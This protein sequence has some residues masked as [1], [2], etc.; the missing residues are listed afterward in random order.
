MAGFGVAYRDK[1]IQKSQEHDYTIVIHEQSPADKTKRPLTEIISPGTFFPEDSSDSEHNLSN[2]VMCIWLH[3]SNATKSMPSQVSIGLA[4][5]DIFTGK[6]ALFQFAATYIHS[7]STYDELER[8]ISAY[9]PSECIF[10]ANIPERLIDDIIGFVGLEKT[11]MHKVGGNPPEP[12][13]DKKSSKGGLEACEAGGVTPLDKKMSKG[14]CGGDPPSGL[15]LFAKNAEKQNYQLQTLKR[16]F[17]HLSSVEEMFP[18]HYIATQAFCFL[19][20]FV[21]QH[22]PNLSKKLTEPVFENYTDRLILANQTLNQLNI[23]DDSRYSGKMRSLSSFLNNCVTLMG[24]R[25]FLYQ[26]HYPTTHEPTLQASYDITEHLLLA[27]QTLAQQ[28]YFSYAMGNYG[29]DLISWY[30]LKDWLKTR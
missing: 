12:P 21:D 4:N 10:I 1:Y 28:T 18:T 2:N 17:P 8:Y 6:T 15:S 20:D 16:F 29:F 26:L 19:L 7:P 5:I 3:K 23:T 13:L 30:T 14:G 27:Q 24:K 9:K 25:Q 22:N 11:K